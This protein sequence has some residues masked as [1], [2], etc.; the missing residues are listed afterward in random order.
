MAFIRVQNLVRQED[1]T[2]SAGT[3]SIIDTIYVKGAKYHSKQRTRERLGKVISLDEGNRSGVFLSPTRGLVRYDAD[4]DC[5]QTLE[6]KDLAVRDEK[7]FPQPPVH[8]VFGDS[9]LL[10]QFLQKSGINVILR[11]VFSQNQDYQ[12]LLC[13]VLHGIL[14][15]GSK[16][17]CDNFIAKS[18]AAYVLPDVPLSSLRSDTRFFSMMGD[19]RVRMDFFS[20]F[21][22]A[23]RQHKPEFG[24]C[25]YVDST[26]LPN[27]IMDNPFNALSCHGIGQSSCQTRLVLVLDEETGFPVWYDLIPGNVLDVSTIMNVVNDVASSLGIEIDSLVLDAGY[28]SRELLNAFHIGSGKNI[29]ARMPARRGYPFK[30]LYREVKALIGK[31][32]YAFVRNKHVYFGKAKKITLFGQEIYAYVYVDQNNALQRFR[33]YVLEHDDE[34][35]QMTDKDKD[36]LAVKNG[37]FVLLSTR[38]ASPSQILDLYFERTAI[39]TVFK[40]SKDYLGLLPLNKWSDLTVR[41]KILFD[42][43]DTI[44]V[45]QLRKAIDAAGISVSELSGTTQSLMCFMNSH[46][47]VIVDTPNKKTKAYYKM[48]SLQVPA[49]VNI[50]KFQKEVLLLNL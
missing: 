48:L 6:R 18:F 26:P 13:H 41:G 28:V 29:I 10:L 35:Q 12:R 46:A 31:G 32:K 50:N 49:K 14:K 40:T 9:F 38:Q 22:A 42:I 44:I 39:E 17:S 37:F 16:I 24:K 27:D 7:L 23:M 19:D 21:I 33:D 3:A 47:Q 1:G 45:L 15:D 4:S 8:T 5:F 25:C 2:I 11:Q 34:Y 30:G 43:I 20:K 36:W